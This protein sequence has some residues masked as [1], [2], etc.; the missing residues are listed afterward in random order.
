M[1]KQRWL[2]SFCYKHNIY[3]DAVYWYATGCINIMVDVFSLSTCRWITPS[4]PGWTQYST[5]SFCEV[6]I[7]EKEICIREYYEDE[8]HQSPLIFDN[9][10]ISNI[11]LYSVLYQKHI[12]F[13][14]AIIDPKLKGLKIRIT[15]ESFRVL[16]D[17][18]KIKIIS[19]LMPRKML[20]L[21]DLC[22][23]AIKKNNIS[24][25]NLPIADEEKK[26]FIN[27]NFHV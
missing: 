3:R 12:S 18:I 13:R 11:R 2:G 4:K 10:A 21:T 1:S 15:S 5:I 14:D 6:F 17:K 22:V 24:F 26:K 20:P 25:D 27:Y 19:E 16:S 7:S 8:D 9:I 23:F